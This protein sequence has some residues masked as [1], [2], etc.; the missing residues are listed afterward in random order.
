M[1]VSTG[2]V[3]KSFQREVERIEVARGTQGH[4]GA[5][6]VLSQGG[7][8]LCNAALGRYPNRASSREGN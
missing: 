5:Q 3:L 1:L 8:A 2:Q 7:P 6:T 4:A